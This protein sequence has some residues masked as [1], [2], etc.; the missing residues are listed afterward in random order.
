[1]LILITYLSYL[2]CNLVYLNL[3][4]FSEDTNALLLNSVNKIH[5]LLL[6]ISLLVFFLILVQYYNI[7]FNFLQKN[8]ILMFNSV[9]SIKYKVVLSIYTLYL[10]G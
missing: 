1:M 7:D 5:P 4:V 3:K 6:Y 8:E 10:G 2:N 9:S